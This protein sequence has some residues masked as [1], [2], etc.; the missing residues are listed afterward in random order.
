MLLAML[1]FAH[2]LLFRLVGLAMYGVMRK[3]RRIARANVR[4]CYP[5]LFSG[6]CYSIR[7]AE[8]IV[9]RSFLS[10]GQTL[11]DFLLLPVYTAQNID[12]YVEVKNLEYLE[13]AVPV[14]EHEV[15]RDQNAPSLV[16]F[17][18]ERE[19]DFHLLSVLLH[20]PDVIERHDVELVEAAQ[21]PLETEVPLRREQP[22]HEPERGR[23][24][25]PVSS[26]DELVTDGRNRVA[27]PSPR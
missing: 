24:Q 11:G 17:G 7:V 10:L 9:R 4:S 14:G 20:V 1:R 27:L 16:A 19:E 2:H 22:L 23:E 26:L 18:E 6:R 12:R 13:D 5:F 15:A 25:D 21:L 8:R 3:R